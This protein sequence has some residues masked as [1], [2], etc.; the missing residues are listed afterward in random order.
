M[1]ISGGVL[2]GR[3]LPGVVGPGVRPTA[4]RVREALFSLLGQ[5]LSGWSW[6]DAFGG[7]GL[8]AAEAMS[9]G[10]APVCIVER[11]RRAAQSIRRSMEALGL[12]PELRVAEA[13]RVLQEGHWD[14]VFLDPPY[15]EDPLIWAQRGAAAARVWLVLEHR[16]G[17]SL[18][19]RLG[20]LLLDRVRSY[21]DTTLTLYRRALPE[22]Q[23]AQSGAGGPDSG[24]QLR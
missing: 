16:S 23:H 11:N 10:A 19:D 5:D 12:R 20:E 8:I 13:E 24:A 6:L 14:V 9:R 21:G 1:R 15:V 4:G 2:R 22:Q 17:P 7:S 3:E 18:P